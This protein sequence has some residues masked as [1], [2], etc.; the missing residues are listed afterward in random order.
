MIK[1]VMSLF[2][3]IFFI[4]GNAQTNTPAHKQSLA[5]IKLTG[6]LKPRIANIVGVNQDNQLQLNLDQHISMRAASEVL[7]ANPKSEYLNKVALYDSLE[8]IFFDKESASVEFKVYKENKNDSEMVPGRIEADFGDIVSICSYKFYQDGGTTD[9]VIADIEAL[10]NRTPILDLSLST[11][12]YVQKK[13]L[14]FAEK[15]H[16]LKEKTNSFFA[17]VVQMSRRSALVP[18]SARR[19]QNKPLVCS[20]VQKMADFG[21]KMSM[22]IFTNNRKGQFLLWQVGSKTIPYYTLIPPENIYATKTDCDKSISAP[23]K[24]TGK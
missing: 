19:I 13:S 16:D 6:E 5:L 4:A 20:P 8:S 22:V 2:V 23:K 15:E 3:F 14:V 7:I 1:I 17:P 21:S 11:C 9:S 24:E 18:I 10:V 12:L